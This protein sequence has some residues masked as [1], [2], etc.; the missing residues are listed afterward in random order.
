MYFTVAPAAGGSLGAVVARETWVNLRKCICRVVED[1]DGERQERPHDDVL[2]QVRR[3]VHDAARA[4][5][6][7]HVQARGIAQLRGL[8]QHLPARL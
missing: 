8:L 7:H 2:R 4:S 3:H 5:A 6:A 1:V